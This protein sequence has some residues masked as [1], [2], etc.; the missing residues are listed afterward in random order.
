MNRINRIF[1]DRDLS[2]LRDRSAHATPR[3]LEH[4]AEH[5]LRDVAYVLSLTRRVKEAII[6]DRELASS[7]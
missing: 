7:E 2:L 6:S 1:N 4:D 3:R 5:T